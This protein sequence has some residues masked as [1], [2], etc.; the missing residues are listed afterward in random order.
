MAVL[1]NTSFR[2]IR[3]VALPIEHGGWAFVYEPIL[4]GLL[5]VPSVAGFFLGVAGLGIFLLY[6]PTQIPLKDRLKGKRYPRTAW[7]ERFVALYGM[8]AIGSLL[9]TSL[10]ARSQFW[11]AIVLAIPFAGL[12]MLLVVRGRVREAITEIS[13]AVSFAGLTPAILLASG[14]D[15]SYALAMWLVP[16]SRAVTSIL[17]IRVR[18]RRSRGD[19]VNRI[20][21]LAAHGM[22][23]LMLGVAWFANLLPITLSRW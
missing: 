20:I 4:L 3:N 1:S 23:I 22:G 10:T 11:I 6:Q 8:L 13:G 17:Y 12:Q 18:L 2:S 5:L 14:G 16:I 19:A 7:A 15:L 9:L 21:P